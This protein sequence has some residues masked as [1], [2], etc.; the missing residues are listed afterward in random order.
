MKNKDNVE[1]RKETKDWKPLSNVG[2]M[3]KLGNLFPEKI[4]IAKSFC[5]FDRLN[6]KQQNVTS[7][8]GR[9]RTTILC[10]F[11]RLTI[12]TV[13]SYFKIIFALY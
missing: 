2:I 10:S 11:G 7:I 13:Y 1:I 8:I 3:M 9:H 4:S 6:G 12:P 5:G